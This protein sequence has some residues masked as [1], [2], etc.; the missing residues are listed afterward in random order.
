MK[1]RPMLPLIFFLISACG[2]A[3]GTP[4]NVPV[5]SHLQTLCKASSPALGRAGSSCFQTVKGR[6]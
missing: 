6:W 2:T 5:T 4:P 3:E 1:S